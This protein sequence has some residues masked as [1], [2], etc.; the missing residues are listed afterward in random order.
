MHRLLRIPH[1]CTVAPTASTLAPPLSYQVFHS[2]GILQRRWRLKAKQR[3]SEVVEPNCL[4]A[5]SER[6]DV[7]VSMLVPGNVLAKFASA[8]RP[9]PSRPAPAPRARE[10]HAGEWGEHTCGM[11]EWG[12]GGVQRSTIK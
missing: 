3:G 5:E 12:A 10:L 2:S 8:P 11:I 7:D 4:R 1:P 9:R 6:A